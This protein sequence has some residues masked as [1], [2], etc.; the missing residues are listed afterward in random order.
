[1]N[2]GWRRWGKYYYKTDL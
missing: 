1:M 2:K